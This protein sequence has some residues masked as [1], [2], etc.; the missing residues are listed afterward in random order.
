MLALTVFQ[1]FCFILLTI[2]VITTFWRQSRAEKSLTVITGF[3]HSSYI[4]AD[5]LRQSSD[6]LT[7]MV[8]SYAVTG[9]E[10]FKEYFYMIRDIRNGKRPRPENYDRVFWDFIVAEDGLYN[11]IEGERVSLY[12]LMKK[13]GFQDE[14]LELLVEANRRSEQL[15]E[16]EERAMNAMVGLFKDA[17]GGYTLKGA[18]DRELALELLFSRDYHLAKKEIM[19]PINRFLISIDERTLNKLTHSQR[20]NRT[21]FSLSVY[22]FTALLILIPILLLSFYRYRLLFYNELNAKK[23]ELATLMKNLPGM[24]YRCLNDERWTMLF[25]S[26]GCFPLTGYRPQELLDKESEVT[27]NEIILPQYRWYIRELWQANLEQKQFVESEYEIKTASGEIKWVLERGYGIYDREG[28]L[29]YIE[30]FIIDISQHKRAIEDKFKLQDQLNHRSRLDAIGQL[31][32]GIAHD[33]NNMLTGITMSAQLL[34]YPERGLDEDGKSLVDM[35]LGAAERTAELTKKL[36]AFGRKAP[37]RLVPL[38]IDEAIENTVTLLKRTLNKK[39]S[40]AVYPFAKNRTVMGDSAML[41]NSLLNIGINA[42]HSMPDGGEIIVHTKNLHLDRHYCD[43]SQFDLTPGE[44]IA[45]EITDTGQG[46]AQENLGRIF[47]PFYTTKE[48]G[49]G[50]GL[51]LSM[52]YGMVVQHHGAVE[53]ESELGKGTTFCLLLP[54]AEVIKEQGENREEIF[55]KAGVIL[56]V[57][58]EE[59]IRRAGKHLLKK[60]GYEVI[61]AANGKEAIEIFQREYRTID[62]VILDMVMPEMDGREAFFKM[63]EIDKTCRIIITSGYVQDEVIDD[64]KSWGLDGFLHKPFTELELTRLIYD[65]LSG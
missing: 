21:L 11:G 40:I 25:V 31:A 47:E 7:R 14:E 29:L 28:R 62:L 23:R 38:N 56:L 32:G 63:K 52:V 57:D 51:G 45:L 46:I 1:F 50:T 12:N 20:M 26:E 59:I 10:R 49:K 3:R 44:Y 34:K 39:I 19:G 4:L 27:Y 35:I 53:V 36:L 24:V 54:C 58:D 18:P 55:V 2:G 30:G 15:I 8:R 41:H 13:A 61:V 48:L 65:V 43:N 17:E 64:I 16:L 37:T 42:G 5:Q 22:L 33:F 6:D 9:D 60:I